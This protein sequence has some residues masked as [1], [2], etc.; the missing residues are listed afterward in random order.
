VTH[1]TAAPAIL[2]RHLG[3]EDLDGGPTHVEAGDTLLLEGGWEALA[4]N[5][6][7]PDVLVVDDPELVRRQVAPMGAR[8]RRALI[9]LAGL[10]SLLVTGLTPPVVAGLLATSALIL[11][12]VLT[13]QEAYRAVD[14]T[15]VVLVGGLLPLAI[16][17]ETT[18]AAETLAY[19]RWPSSG[20]RVP[21]C[22]CSA[23]ASS[24]RSSA[25]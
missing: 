3:L 16:A 14:R 1:V 22:C 23:C 21:T 24:L 19:G 18:G 2:P 6:A 10:F 5:L 4:V 7:D 13:V 12:R 9:V 17:M 25:S 15:A 20:R 11:L 8:G